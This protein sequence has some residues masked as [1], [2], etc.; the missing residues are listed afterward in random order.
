MFKVGFI[1]SLL[2]LLVTIQ[3][4]FFFL[5]KLKFS[6]LEWI[7]FNACAV[8]NITYLSGYILF[9]LFAEK[10]L[11][12]AAVLPLV[13]FGTGGL[14]VFSWKGMN[15]IPQISHLIMTL[16]AAY[17]VWLAFGTGDFKVASVG[18]FIGIPVFS[19]FIAFQQ[20]YAYTHPDKLAKIMNP[21][22]G[23]GRKV[24]CVQP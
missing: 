4:T 9:L 13:F 24:Q 17:V 20:R 23:T 5:K 11:M 1:L 3:S 19:A 7:V 22:V 8:A 16:N 2:L 12:Y 15:I 6:V 21:P 14:F 18:L 10:I